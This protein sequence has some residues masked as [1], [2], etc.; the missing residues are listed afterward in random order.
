MPNIKLISQI[1]VKKKVMTTKYL[2]K[3]Q[4]PM[5]VS[6]PNIIQPE[7]ISKLICNLW[8]YTLIPKIKSISQSIAKKVVTT[9][10]LAKFQSPRAISQPKIIGP[11]RNV[12]LICTSSLF[13]HIPKNQVNITKH[14]EKKWWQLNIWPNFKVQGP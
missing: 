10:Y 5:A 11:E 7:W 14:S 13:T 4:S 3:F 9:K 8:L 1:I 12:N 6:W 2:A